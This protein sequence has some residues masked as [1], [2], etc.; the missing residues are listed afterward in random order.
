[1]I[2]A[3]EGVGGVSGGEAKTYDAFPLTLL[4]QSRGISQ[5]IDTYDTRHLD[6]KLVHSGLAAPVMPSG[7]SSRML[8]VIVSRDASRTGPLSRG[9][10]QDLASQWRSAT[11]RLPPAISPR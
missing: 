4:A 1:M 10:T 9:G 11:P 6:T 8:P 3:T 5:L 2:E 7:R